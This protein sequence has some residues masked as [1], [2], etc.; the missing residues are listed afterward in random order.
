MHE[1]ANVPYL[2]LSR[3]SNNRFRLGSK[4]EQRPVKKKKIKLGE[5]FAHTNTKSRISKQ[6]YQTESSR[7]NQVLYSG[8]K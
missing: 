2:L 3:L 4:A 5:N 7:I 1:R 6:K 8:Y